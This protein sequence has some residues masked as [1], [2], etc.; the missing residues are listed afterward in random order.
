VVLRWS[1]LPLGSL[2]LLSCKGKIMGGFGKIYGI[3]FNVI[4]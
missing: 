1:L 4:I 2:L 3:V